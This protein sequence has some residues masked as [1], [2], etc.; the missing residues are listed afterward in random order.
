MSHH[1]KRRS[2]W[3]DKRSTHAGFSKWWDQHKKSPVLLHHPNFFR[4]ILMKQCERWIFRWSMNKKLSSWFVKGNNCLKFIL[5]FLVNPKKVLAT[6]GLTNHV[7]SN[8]SLVPRDTPR[9][10]KKVVKEVASEKTFYINV[11]SKRV[12]WKRIGTWTQLEKDSKDSSDELS[13]GLEDS[14]F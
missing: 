8:S 5:R 12:I 6:G 3:R 1:L 2:E 9:F 4:K 11:L 13:L 14:G 7:I 10:W